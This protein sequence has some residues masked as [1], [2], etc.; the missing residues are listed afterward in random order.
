MRASAIPRPVA[1]A[2]AVAFAVATILYTAIWMYYVR[3]QPAAELGAELR[4]RSGRVSD[5]IEIGRVARNSA[6][7]AAGLRSGDIIL[8]VNNRPVHDLSVPEAIARGRP[9]EVV[10]LVVKDPR[11]AVPLSMRA[12]LR[13]PT[14]GAMRISAQIVAIQLLDSYPVLFLVVGLA[15]LF[16]RLDNRNAWLLALMFGGFVAAAPLAFMEG[17]MNPSFRG[18]ALAYMYALWGMLPAVFYFFFATFPVSSPLD[19]RVPWLKWVLLAC[20]AVVALPLAGFVLVT[21]SLYSVVLLVESLPGRPTTIAILTYT[22]GGFGLGLASL[23]WNSVSAPTVEARRKTRVMVWGTVAAMVPALLLSALQLYWRIENFF[24]FPFWIWAPAV[25]AQFLMPLSF[26]YAV[27]KHRVLE[28]PVLLRRSARYLLVQRGFVVLLFIAAAAAIVLF[29]HI[30]LRFFHADSNIGMALS[31]IFGIVLVWVS[32]PVVKRG[33]ERIDRAFFRSAYDARRVLE[34]L[35]QRTRGARGRDKLAELLEGEINQALH[36]TSI[37]VYWEGNDGRL[38]LHHD[39]SR[40]PFEPFLLPDTPLLQTLARRSVPWD[41][42]TRPN[43]DGLGLFGSS[44]PECLVPI[45]SSD[46]RLTGV[47]VLGTRLSEEPYSREDKRLLASVANQAAVVFEN[48]RL[49]EEMAGR[50]E[51]ERRIAQEME[52]ARQVQTRL[53]PQKLPPL[54]T[55][56]YMGECIQARQVGGDYYDFLELRSGRVALVLADIAGKGISGALMMANLQANL[57]SQY[58][59]A[60]EDLGRLLTSVNRLFYENSGDSSYA[61]LFF[62]DYEDSSRRFRYVNCGHLPPLL[63]RASKRSQGRD[64]GQ[65]EVER[66]ESTC[67]V[68]GLFED[69]HCNVAEVQLSPG[70]T[71]VLY[72][73]GVTEAARSDGEEFGARRLLETLRAYDHLPVQSLLRAIVAAVQQFTCGEQQDDITMVVAR[74]KVSESSDM[75]RPSVANSPPQ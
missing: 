42:D 12:T 35:V 19:R 7:D 28:I 49:A 61:T 53:L 36:P 4:I 17:E 1:M 68:L 57:R 11:V 10:S 50:I 9:G 70:D 66:L 51:A 21:R 67:T 69:W 31:A 32:S 34:N 29:T 41:V 43:G 54:K 55:L 18:F 37:A 15:V 75:M 33:T 8:A 13:A 3:W 39:N 38:N 16:L 47:I 52:F 62:G 26:G 30:F 71:L 58:A 72:T 48:I 25:L 6:A 64:S 60:L 40:S 22:L 56:E 27:L 24:E 5:Q 23:I 44:Q 2:A 45:L 65:F 74:C 63:L 59:M 73:D 20:G 46:S 14:K